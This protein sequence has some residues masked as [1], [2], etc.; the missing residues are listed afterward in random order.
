MTLS[1]PDQTGGG[2]ARVSL[3]LPYRILDLTDDRGGLAGML[4]AQL[5]ADVIAVEPPQ[6]QRTRRLAPF[7]GDQ[8]GLEQSLV[9]RALNRGKRSVVVEGQD[10]IERLVAGADVVLHSGA[11][12]VDLDALRAA[13]PHLVTVN[14]TPF[15]E[16]GPK[17]GWAATDLT[18][19]AASGTMSLT[20][21]KT[22]HRCGSANP[23][24]GTSRAWMQRVQRSWR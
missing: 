24:C 21:E 17:A 6:G 20:G 23:W 15:G 16:T 3:A 5:G 1:D 2:G 8:P 19:A 13:H 10:D 14:I 12:D 18:L 22:G 11:M 7:A 4:L 9:H